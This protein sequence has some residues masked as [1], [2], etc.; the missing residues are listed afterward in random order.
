MKAKTLDMSSKAASFFLPYLL[1]RKRGSST[2]R[3][4][5]PRRRDP[6]SSIKIT[7]PRKIAIQGAMRRYCASR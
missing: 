2:S 6:S 1:P 3:R 7:I 4:A 5:S